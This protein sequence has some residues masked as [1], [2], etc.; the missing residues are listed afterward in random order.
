MEYIPHPIQT[1]H[2]RLDDGV[3]ELA[4]L[5]AKNTHEIWA[6]GRMDQGWRWGPARDDARKEHPCLVP[7]EDLPESEKEYDRQ[8]ALETLKA[9]TAMGYE[10]RPERSGDA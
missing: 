10:I 2:I 8:T 7:Y 9:I 1:G 5:L 3:L 4:E 6:Q